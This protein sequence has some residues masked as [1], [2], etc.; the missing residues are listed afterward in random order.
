M[1]R[2]ARWLLAVGT[3]ALFLPSF[4]LH[5]AGG[6]KLVDNPFYTHWAKF[7][8]GSTVTRVEKTTFSG[9]EKTNFPDGIDHKEV[10]YKLLEVSPKYVAVQVIV[11][12]RNFLNI[13]ESAPTKHFYPAKVTPEHLRAGLHDVDVKLGKDSIEVLG[14]KMECITASG[15]EKKDGLEIDHK[16]WLSEMVPGGIV[17]QHRSTRQDGKMYAHTTIHVKAFKVME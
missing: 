3:I 16:V 14:K 7:K 11:K 6:D 17:Q 10:T 2:A 13:T 12:E 9:P 1:V 8:V 4:P 5:G 15:A